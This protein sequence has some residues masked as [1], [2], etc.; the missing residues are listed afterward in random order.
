[1]RALLAPVLLLVALSAPAIAQH[2]T[3]PGEQEDAISTCVAGLEPC[4]YV[5]DDNCEPE[6]GHFNVWIY[7]E[8]NGHPGLQRGD[9]ITDDTCHG[10]IEADTVIF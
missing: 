9:E 1:M 8:T 4:F 5:D 10:M 2:C 6:C 3:E 7:Q